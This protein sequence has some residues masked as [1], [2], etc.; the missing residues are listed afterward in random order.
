M[1]SLYWKIWFIDGKRI[2]ILGDILFS[3][4]A[5]SNIIRLQKLGAQLPSL[6]LVRSCRKHSGDGCYRKPQITASTQKARS[7]L[8]A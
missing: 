4:V 2:T 8:T 6:V 3:R 5:R 1:P 7:H